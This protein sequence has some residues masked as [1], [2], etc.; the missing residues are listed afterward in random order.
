MNSKDFNK[1][2]EEMASLIGIEDTIKIYEYFR[3]QQIIFP[4][5]LYSKE[6]VIKYVRENYDGTNIKELSRKFDYSD[7]RIRQFLFEN[8]RL[9]K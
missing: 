1:I 3:G 6:Y 9:E 2:Y 7:R 8:K 4:Q 5:R